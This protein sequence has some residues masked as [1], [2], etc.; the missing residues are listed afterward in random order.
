MNASTWFVTLLPSAT[1]MYTPHRR[2]FQPG[3]HYGE[4]AGVGK[5]CTDSYLKHAYIIHVT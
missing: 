4:V 1:A 3:E 2:E 5:V